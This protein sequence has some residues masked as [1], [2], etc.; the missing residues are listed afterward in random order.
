MISLEMVLNWEKSLK[1]KLKKELVP[2]KAVKVKRVV[3]IC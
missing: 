3:Y 1:C 2:G